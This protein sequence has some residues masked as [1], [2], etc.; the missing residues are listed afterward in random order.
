MAVA[1]LAPLVAEEPAIL[2]RWG[3]IAVFRV[4]TTPSAYIVA[5]AAG[6]ESA[7]GMRGASPCRRRESRTR[8]RPRTGRRA[9]EARACA[10]ERAELGRGL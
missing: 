4:V 2:S 9:V 1:L 5:L 10:P 7:A 3:L 8:R 6:D